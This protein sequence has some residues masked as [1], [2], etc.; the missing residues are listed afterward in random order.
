MSDKTLKQIGKDLKKYRTSK[1]YKTLIEFCS[2]HNLDA[3]T[4]ARLEKGCPTPEEIF[5]VKL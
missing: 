2:E 1:Q 4:I 3:R 5:N